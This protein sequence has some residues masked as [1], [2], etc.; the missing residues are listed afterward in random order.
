M[1]VFEIS[2]IFGKEGKRSLSVFF[3]VG[4]LGHGASAGH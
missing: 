2:S 1:G 4:I 3:Q